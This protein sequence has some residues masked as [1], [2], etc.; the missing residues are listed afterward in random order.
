M[1]AFLVQVR[2]VAGPVQVTAWTGEDATCLALGAV[3][4]DGVHPE[5]CEPFWPS[6]LVLDEHVLVCVDADHDGRA[7][8]ADVIV[9]DARRPHDASHRL[10]GALVT[11]IV[12][13]QAH[14]CSVFL[15]GEG[16]AWCFAVSDHTTV[17]IVEAF[18]WIASF[19][20]WLLVRHRT[21]ARPTRLEV[22]GPRGGTVTLVPYTPIGDQD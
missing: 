21:D 16:S 8:L 13:R 19:F 3:R 1:S 5:D 18:G 12:D 22:R 11:C 10:T 14:S 2:D 4:I 15:R 7:S 20:H 6:E 9:L 17:E